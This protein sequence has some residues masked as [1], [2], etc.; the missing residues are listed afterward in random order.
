MNED[1]QKL[2]MYQQKIQNDPEFYCRY[3]LGDNP[4]EMQVKIMKAIRDFPRVS[5]KSCHASGKTWCSARI[6]LNFLYAYINSIVLTT[7]PCFDDKTEILTDSGWKF[8]DCL[9]NDDKVAQYNNGYLEFVKSIEY[10][11]YSY[12]GEMIG[13]HSQIM[14]MLVTPEHRCFVNKKIR[15]AKDIYGKWTPIFEREIDWIGKKHKLSNFWF[16]YY[17]FWFAEG[18][19]QCSTRKNRVVVTQKKKE[20]FSYIDNL[21]IKI[22]L[23]NK[24]KKDVKK[25]GTTN[26]TIYDKNMAKEFIT[27]GKTVNKKIPRWILESS[28]EQLGYFYKGF[29]IGDGSKDKNGSE[30][31]STSSK[32]LAND[33]HE[34]CIKIGKIANFKEYH[35]SSHEQY[36]NGL[37][38][39]IKLWNKRGKKPQSKKEFWYKENYNG[40]VYCV[41]VD[42]GLVLVRRNGINHIS[43]NSFRQVEDVLWQEIRSAFSNARCPDAMS[44]EIFQ[45]R[46]NL[47]D[48]WFA[49]GLS[50]DDPDKFQG[51]HS[52]DILVICDEASGIEKSI[53]NAIEGAISTGHTRLLLIGNPTDPTGHFADTFKSDLWKKFTIS[54]FDTP[55]FVSIKNLEELKNSTEEERKKAVMSPYLITPQWA[56]ERMF[57]WGAESPLFQ[58][59]VLGEFPTEAD[60]TLIA[61]RYVEKAIGREDATG[62]PR[63]REGDE[64]QIG[65]DPARFGVDRTAIV[66]RHGNEVVDILWYQKEDTTQTVG[67]AMNI[68]QVYPEAKM[69]IDEIGVGAGV[70][71][72][73]T[74]NENYRERVVGVNVANKTNDDE[75]IKFSNIRAKIYWGLRERFINNNI[76]LID[77][78]TVISDL[79]NIKYRFRSSDGALQIESKEEMKKRGLRSPDIADSLCLAFAELDAPEPNIIWI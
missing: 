34:L 15:L 9:E 4:W 74:E 39:E 45:T 72:Q 60:D 73:L 76:I 70:I 65:L 13:Y 11:R 41:K 71:D 52:K 5:I 19:C 29:F 23:G 40:Y 2:L 16:E 36:N 42:S 47:S 28:K 37:Y 79:T 21:F 49:V 38:Y 59:R 31:L 3:V 55:N 67:R 53:Y 17:G 30:K 50:T 43:G 6:A 10:Y 27:Y 58:A 54:C 18:Y 24:V 14:D 35:S 1:K 66:V 61:L 68:L 69:F 62:K 63:L 32:Q 12:N 44:G 48:G 7:A 33:L 78:G 25:D 64:W 51:Y 8:F 75:N 77:K 20:N 22:G 46:L 57:E 26:W 56:Y